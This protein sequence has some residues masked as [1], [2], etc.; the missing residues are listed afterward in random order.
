MEYSRQ[1]PTR[2][3]CPWN[4]PGK[5][6]VVGSRSLLQ[7][8]FPK[9]GL[10][11]DFLHWRQILYCL[12]HEGI[13]ILNNAIF[14][15]ICISWSHTAFGN[16]TP[17]YDQEVSSKFDHC[18]YHLFYFPESLHSNSIQF[19]SLNFLFIILTQFLYFAEDILF[20]FQETPFF[21]SL[22]EKKIPI[23]L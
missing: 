19:T 9:Q 22:F 13:Y 6:T 17:Y 16:Q 21:L 15:L 1:E 11:L 23:H 7:G 18:H 3:L 2:L 8:I 10:N 5:N 4:S 20:F 12:S 14:L